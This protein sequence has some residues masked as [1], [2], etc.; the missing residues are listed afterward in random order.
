MRKLAIF[1]EGQTEVLFVV[2][3]V[4]EVAGRRNVAVQHVEARGG[5][6]S[7]RTFRTVNAASTTGDEKYFVLVCDCG[8]DN[9][10]ASDVHEQ[11]PSL[12]KSYDG[13]LAIRDVFPKTRSD[14]CTIARA[15]RYGLRT[16]PIETQLVLA[17]MEIEA[18]ILGEVTH[19][20]RLD[21]GLSPALV[22]ATLDFDPSTGTLEDRH[23]PARDLN[24][25]YGAVG[26]T[27][28][29]SRAVVEATLGALD[30]AEVYLTCA[31]RMPSLK[32]LTDHLDFFFSG[33]SWR[34][35]AA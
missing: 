31:A 7:V 4:R 28:D 26:R 34:S 3:L 35:D 14:V 24:D 5:R 6:K 18:W 20:E 1:T 9:R 19:F 10:V 11:Y 32:R 25:A 2:E 8:T 15:M 16:K 21:S 27:W 17:I 33:G 29:K 13:I 30:F 12:S 23:N 22:T